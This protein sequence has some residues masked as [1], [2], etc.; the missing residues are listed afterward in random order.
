[1]SN[2]VCFRSRYPDGSGQIVTTDIDKICF[3]VK[4]LGGMRVYSTRFFYDVDY[5]NM[6]KI[7]DFAHFDRVKTVKM[8]KED[9]NFK[10]EEVWINPEHVLVMG[11][12]NPV[13]VDIGRFDVEIVINH[14]FSYVFRKL[15]PWDKF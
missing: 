2:L 4:G 15:W 6:E 3:V 1:M 7:K 14:S 11:G 10:T 8:D 9:I 12:L 5:I 13:I